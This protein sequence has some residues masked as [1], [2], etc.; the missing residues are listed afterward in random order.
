MRKKHSTT[1]LNSFAVVLALC[2]NGLLH[3]DD[4]MDE[5][6]L[7]PDAIPQKAESIVDRF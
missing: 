2:S 5:L 6:Q 7:V 4:D 1:S 3:D